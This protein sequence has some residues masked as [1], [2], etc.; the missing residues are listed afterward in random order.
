MESIPE[1]KILFRDYPRHRQ[2]LPILNTLGNITGPTH[3]IRTLEAVPK[4]SGTPPF[5]TNFHP[6]PPLTIGNY[7]PRARLVGSNICATLNK[8]NNGYLSRQCEKLPIKWIN[9]LGK[10]ARH[11]KGGT[12][13]VRY[14][15]LD[16]FLF[17]NPSIV[18]LVGDS[19]VTNQGHVFHAR[20][21]P[22]NVN[23]NS[24]G[25]ES[26]KG[27]SGGFW[28]YPE[29]S[30]GR[31]LSNGGAVNLAKVPSNRLSDKYDNKNNGSVLVEEV[32]VA[33]EPGFD[34]PL[35]PIIAQHY[36]FMATIP[37]LAPHLQELVKTPHVH[38]HLNS[39][40]V[41]EIVEEFLR[42]MGYEH[43]LERVVK[44]DV[45]VQG[46]VYVP[47]YTV[48]C[49]VPGAWHVR[50]LR[51]IISARLEQVAKGLQEERD[52]AEQMLEEQL[53]GNDDSMDGREKSQ[54]GGGVESLL[55]ASAVSAPSKPFELDLAPNTILVIRKTE[56][57]IRLANH[58]ELVEMLINT[59]SP[60]SQPTPSSQQSIGS[61][62]VD[63]YNYDIKVISDGTLKP[64]LAETLAAFHKAKI[65]ISPHSQILSN[66]VATPAN[67]S[68][69]EFLPSDDSLSFSYSTLA[70]KLG[71]DWYG[72]F[73]ETSKRKDGALGRHEEVT[74]D[75]EMVK[76][77]V[78]VM[79]RK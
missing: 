35:N 7:L 60:K 62:A 34:E 36:A 38:I 42:F 6:S 69:L 21:V 49:M 71:L 74:V 64:P 72:I 68:V 32:F 41:D 1:K 3:C 65:I 16:T 70:R 2:L 44:G 23:L 63:N 52:A 5:D 15:K 29:S 53:S 37:R 26:T 66:L 78:G 25:G 55:T 22:S 59:Y 77:V 13:P 57:P 67:A 61:N 75:I 12:F 47:D 31:I 18:S 48:Y 33:S 46:A 27:R 9:T 28:M 79:L 43:L 76:A 39:G 50:K 30:C 11:N 10:F 51:E 17:H 14:V 56:G 20:S 73:P 19:L 45:R 54:G 58:D 8:T 40:G 4:T 24:E